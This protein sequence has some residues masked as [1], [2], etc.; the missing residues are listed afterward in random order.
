MWKSERGFTFVEI[1]VVI[2]IGAILVSMA[3]RGFGDASSGMTVR[4]AR[5]SF[6]GL[7]ARTRAIAIERG[8]LTRLRI[9][10][11]NDRVWIE[12]ADG[13]RIDG[14][15]LQQTRGVDVQSTAASPITLCMNPR[16]FA[17]TT[18]NS[19]TGAVDVE[20][21]QGQRRVEVTILPLGQLDW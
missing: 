14:I 7:Q 6:A 13:S 3:V 19:F 11:S 10:T 1:I 16:G 4:G 18:C 20:F 8:E 15:D 2:A 5:E 9:D 12:A 17:D 21:V